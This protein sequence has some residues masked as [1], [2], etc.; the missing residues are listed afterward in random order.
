M[1]GI[2]KNEVG[3]PSNEIK[4]KRRLLITI[5]I[6]LIISPLII[7]LVTNKNVIN[8]KGK[9]NDDK[10]AKLEVYAYTR[11]PYTPSNLVE[12]KKEK[13]N[14]KYLQKKTRFIKNSE[15]NE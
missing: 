2:F 6:L 4:R 3:R 14:R 12:G 5:L 11:L 1:M 7:L 15:L 13:G 10:K 8:L 9:A